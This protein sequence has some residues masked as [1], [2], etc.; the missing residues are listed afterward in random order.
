MIAEGF[1]RTT[2]LVMGILPQVGQLAAQNPT[3]WKGRSPAMPGRTGERLDR[4]SRLT[5]SRRPSP[6]GPGLRIR[7]TGT[8][9]QID[10]RGKTE[11]LEDGDLTLAGPSPVIHGFFR[12]EGNTRLPYFSTMSLL[13]RMC[14]AVPIQGPTGMIPAAKRKS[15]TY[16]GG[17]TS[18]A[19][20]IACWPAWPQPLPEGDGTQEGRPEAIGEERPPSDRDLLLRSEPEMLLVPGGSSSLGTIVVPLINAPHIRSTSPLSKSQREK[21]PTISIIFSS[22]RLVIGPRK[23][24]VTGGGGE[25][26]HSPVVLISWNDAVGLLSLAE[27]KNRPHR[28]TAH[29]GRVGEGGTSDW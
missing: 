10:G 27:R 14:L 7:S 6:S 11:G 9:S 18:F 4:R 22:K 12:V 8:K 26:T 23:A 3:K 5:P 17:P 13:D 16:R 15:L 2:L 1:W 19:S 21:L 29:R 24:H 20:G 25:P 28:S